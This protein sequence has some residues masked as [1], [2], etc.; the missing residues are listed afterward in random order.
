MKFLNG[1]KNSYIFDE[2]KGNT[3]GQF[4]NG[5]FE[6]N[7]EEIIRVLKDRYEIDGVVDVAFTEVEAIVVDKVVETVDNDA[8]EDEL[9]EV[10]EIIVPSKT[11]IK[12]MNQGE[13]KLEMDKYGLSFKIGMKNDDI[14]AMILQARKG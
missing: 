6:T 13:L 12:K 8:E 10:K 4:K 9:P 2:V 11:N 5:V 7:D 1:K 3:L 14:R